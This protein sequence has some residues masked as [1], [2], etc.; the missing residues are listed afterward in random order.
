MHF[1]IM[2]R[3]GG[4]RASYYAQVQDLGP[5]PPLNERTLG[6]YIHPGNMHSPASRGAGHSHLFHRGDHPA[7][8]GRLPPHV[9]IEDNTGGMVAIEPG[10]L[11]RGT[12]QEREYFTNPLRTIPPGSP[13][14]PRSLAP[15]PER[16]F[17]KGPGSI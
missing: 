14:M 13:E 2:R 4:V 11:R 7:T 3:R 16:K 5:L 6:A 9:E 1:D 10:D 17:P 8:M 15:A 12:R